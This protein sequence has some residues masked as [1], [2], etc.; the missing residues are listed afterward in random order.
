SNTTPDSAVARTPLGTPFGELV[1]E[2]LRSHAELLLEQLTAPD[3]RAFATWDVAAATATGDDSLDA[4]AAA[5]RGLVAA[6]L[7]TRDTRHRGRARAVFDRMQAVF[8]AAGARLYVAT[9]APVDAV[10]YTPLRFA[11][12]QSALRDMYELVAVRPGE[13]ALAATIEDQLARL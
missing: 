1:R 13:Q 5:L 2:R 3:G 11:L 12:V 6:Y 10:Q 8:F 9:P 4:H 7:A